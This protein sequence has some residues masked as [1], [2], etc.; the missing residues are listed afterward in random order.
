MLA[1]VLDLIDAQNSKVKVPDIL[2]CECYEE[3]TG[4]ETVEKLVEFVSRITYIA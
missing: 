1:V 3:G 2:K 4:K